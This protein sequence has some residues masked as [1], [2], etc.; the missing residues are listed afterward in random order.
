MKNPLQATWSHPFFWC[1]KRCRDLEEF[2][3]ISGSPERVQP[4]P[5]R[6][7][8]RFSMASLAAKSVFCNLEVSNKPGFSIFQIFLLLKLKVDSGKNLNEMSARVPW[9]QVFLEVGMVGFPNMFHD[10]INSLH[11]NITT[12]S[13]K[14]HSWPSWSRDNSLRVDQRCPNL[15]VF[16]SKQIETSAN[17]H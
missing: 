7:R 12:P 8:L 14:T 9:W 13:T 2:S 3:N 17:L 16:G 6:L 10:N 15:Q 11:I 5:M 1:T 4:R